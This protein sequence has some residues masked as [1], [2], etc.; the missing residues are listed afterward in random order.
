[1]LPLIDW[2]AG[3][4]EGL[5]SPG[6]VITG[7]K[8]AVAVDTGAGMPDRRVPRPLDDSPRGLLCT[9]VLLLREVV[10]LVALVVAAATG[11]RIAS[12]VRSFLEAGSSSLPLSLALPLLLAAPL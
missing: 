1:M 12:L 5:P 8:N 4:V 9:T 6:R 3:T 7:A 2:L 10:M 11:A